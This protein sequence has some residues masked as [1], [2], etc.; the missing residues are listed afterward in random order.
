MASERVQNGVSISRAV[1]DDDSIG[2]V[3]GL[4]IEQCCTLFNCL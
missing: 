2:P 1:R 4:D 3:T